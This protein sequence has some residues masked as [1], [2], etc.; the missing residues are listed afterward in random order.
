[1]LTGVAKSRATHSYHRVP[2]CFQCFAGVFAALTRG[3]CVYPLQLV[4]A[5]ERARCGQKGAARRY[6]AATAGGAGDKEG[7]DE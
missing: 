2:C 3:A 1:M 6:P 5:E 4:V 7:V